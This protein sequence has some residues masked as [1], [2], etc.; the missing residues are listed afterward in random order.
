MWMVLQLAD[1]A[2]PA[3]G[4]A[5][6]A[7]LEAAAQAREV[8]GAQGVARFVRDAIWQA[9]WGAL[10]LVRSRGP[11]APAAPIRTRV[12]QTVTIACLHGIGPDHVIRSAHDCASCYRP[13]GPPPFLQSGFP[14]AG[15]RRAGCPRQ[16][17]RQKS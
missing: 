14:L 4:F 11:I 9:G 1:S 5:H 10:P 17:W 3:G 6:S 2:F 8:E 15:V 16:A 12:C 7:G 13:L